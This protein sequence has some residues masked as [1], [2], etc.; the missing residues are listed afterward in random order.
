[1]RYAVLSYAHITVLL[2]G[3]K[4]STKSDGC[5]FFSVFISA[6]VKINKKIN[7]KIYPS[8]GIG[9]M[10]LP[11]WMGVWCTCVYVCWGNLNFK[12][13]NLLILSVM[14]HCWIQHS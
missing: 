9:D 10:V 11:V 4:S 5:N 1:M 8:Q 13:I 3:G 7:K 2:K 14:S 6:H 12:L